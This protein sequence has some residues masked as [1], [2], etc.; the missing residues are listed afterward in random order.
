MNRSSVSYE[1]TSGDISTYYKSSQTRGEKVKD[2][3]IFKEI[4]AERYL[5][6]MKTINT[7]MQET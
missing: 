2:E 5:N 1:T 6:L 3:K 7:H 4:M